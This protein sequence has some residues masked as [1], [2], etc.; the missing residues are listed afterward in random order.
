MHFKNVFDGES[1]T[2]ITKLF[3]KENELAYIP[4]VVY[5]R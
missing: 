2:L 4:I 3:S 5:E 1:K